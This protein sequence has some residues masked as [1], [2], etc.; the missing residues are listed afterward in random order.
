[1]SWRLSSKLFLFLAGYGMKK[2]ISFVCDT[3]QCCWSGHLRL[4][5]TALL[6][7]WW[8]HL[9]R[10]FTLY[11]YKNTFVQFSYWLWLLILWPILH[12][13]IY[14]RNLYVSVIAEIYF[15][16]NFPYICVHLFKAY[17]K[18]EGCPT[19]DQHIPDEE[20][21]EVIWT[22]FV[23]SGWADIWNHLGMSSGIRPNNKNRL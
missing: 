4:K 17:L 15:L 1:M 6:T 9:P 16:V 7:S 13:S 2:V 18:A 22:R 8:H 12:F 14:T 19:Q 21:H 20:A 3:N 10:C 11:F 23:I 5:K